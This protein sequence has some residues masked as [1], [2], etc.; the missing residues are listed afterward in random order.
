S[1]IFTKEGSVLSRGLWGLS[2]LSLLSLLLY[3]TGVQITQY[4]LYEHVTKVDEK[5]SPLMSF[6][7]ITICNVNRACFSSLTTNDLN[8]VGAMLGLTDEEQ[9][10]GE[11]LP[12]LGPELWKQLANLANF[13]HFTPQSFNMSEFYCRAGHRMEDMLKSCRFHGEK[14]N[15]SHFD[16]VSTPTSLP[17]LSLPETPT[18]KHTYAHSRAHTHTLSHVHTNA[19]CTMRTHGHTP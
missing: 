8:W 18:H 10:V 2:F 3:H 14:C 9:G 6:P 16:K 5:A 1:H 12:V 4:F 19:H 7:A 15:L 11:A 13:S 17:P